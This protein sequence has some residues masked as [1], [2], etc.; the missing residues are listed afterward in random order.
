MERERI[1]LEREKLERKLKLA[2]LGKADRFEANKFSAS[3]EVRLVPPFDELEV[4]KYFQH[5]EKVAESLR[6]PTEYWHLMLQSVIKGKAQRAYSALSGDDASRYDMVK[7]A[8]LTAYEL[9]QF[10][11]ILFV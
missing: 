9:V 7:Q 2:K 4:D 6:W 3:R 5:F 8:I 11:S 10:N 1:E